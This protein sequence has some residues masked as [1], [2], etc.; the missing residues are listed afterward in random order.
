MVCQ[1]A[2]LLSFESHFIKNLYFVLFLC[3][4]PHCLY[5]QTLR[6]VQTWKDFKLSEMH[7]IGLILSTIVLLNFPTRLE[8]SKN[9]HPAGNCTF[10]VAKSSFRESTQT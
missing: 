2:L 3:K 4:H 1:T 10:C 8:E 9:T 7:R 6:D 5:D